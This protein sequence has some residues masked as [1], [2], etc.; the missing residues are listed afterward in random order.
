MTAL[1]PKAGERYLILAPHPDDETLAAGGLI[2]GAV[3]S[4][5]H[6]KII[7]LTSGENNLISAIFYH[8]KPFPGRSD[9]E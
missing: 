1:G 6:V 3:R 9:F 8:K 4:A 5:A 2:Q 7:Y